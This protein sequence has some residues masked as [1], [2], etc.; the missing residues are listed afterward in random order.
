LEQFGKYQLIRQLGAGGMAEVFLARTTVAQ[1]LAKHLVIKKIHPAFA[2]SKH[3]VTM[4]VDEAKIALGL[5]HPNIVQ[6]FDF[7]HVGQTYYLAM[8]HVEGLD[9]LRL[10]QEGARQVKRVPY[11]LCAYIVQ[12]VAKGLDYAHRKP[13]EWGEPLG[14]VHRDVSP[15]NIIISW[16]GAVKIVDF[17][18]A[19]ARDVHEEEGV[20]KGKF[21]YMS[22]EQARGEPVDHRSDVFSA[23]IVLYELAC[24]RPLFYGKGKDVLEQVKSGKIP[25]PREHDPELPPLLEDIILKALAT[26]RDQRFTTARDLQNALGRFQQRHAAEHDE[27]YDSGQLAQFVATIVR[28]ERPARVPA[29]TLPPHQLGGG[30]RGTPAL[31]VPTFPPSVATPLG[32]APAPGPPAGA[33]A[34]GTE[35]P[36]RGAPPAPIASPPAVSGAKVSS[37][38]AAPP[39]PLRSPRTVSNATPLSTPALPEATGLA[40]PLAPGLVPAAAPPSPTGTPAPV[41]PADAV[42]PAGKR[43]AQPDHTGDTPPPVQHETR[44]RKHVL[45]IEGELSGLSS[46]RRHVG[47]ERAAQTV[48]DF[49]RIAEHIAFKHDA[50][51]HRA[52]DAQ[53]TGFTY[54][55]GLPVAGEDDPSRAIRLA[56]ALVDALDGIGRDVVPELRLSV[57]MQRGVAVVRRAGKAWEYELSLSTTA[58]ARRLAAEAQGG[59]VLV[60]G[61]VFQVARSEWNFEELGPIDLPDGQGNTSPGTHQELD[62]PAPK[63]SRVYR[64]RGPKERAERLRARDRG[65]V[66]LG[67][68]LELKALRDHYREALVR[69]EKRYVII[70]G[71]QGVGKRTLVSSFLKSI[72]AGEA[73][74]MR[75]QARAATSDTPYAIIADLGRDMLGL[76]EGAEPRE[77]QRRIQAAVSLFFPG[78]D[79]SREMRGL[80][81]TMG[82]LMGLKATGTG[83][84]DIDAD[85]RRHRMSQALRRIEERLSKDRPLIV[86]T[87]DVHFADSASWEVFAELLGQRTAAP[88][89]GIATARPDERILKAVEDNGATLLMVDELPPNERIELVLRRFAPGEDAT[90]LAREIVAKAGGNPFFLNEML[91][92]LVERGILAETPGT[93]AGSAASVGAGSE[94]P[95][96]EKLLRWLRQGQTVQVPASV[97]VLVATRL[98]RLPPRHKEALSRAA[99]IGRAFTV[100]G[101]ESLTGHPAAEELVQLARR[102]LLDADATGFV[103]RNEM[104]QQVAYELVPVDERPTLHRR[105]AE[106]LATAPGYRAGQDDAR[107]AHHLELAGDHALAAERWLRAARHAL[108]VRAGAEA[109]RHFSRALELLPRSAHAERFAAH[110]ERELLLRAQAM[111]PR[112]LREIHLMRREAETL[113]EPAKVSQALTRLAQL[114]LDVGRQPAARR[115]LVHALAAAQKAK[116]SLAE[117]AV[118]RTQ[119]ALARAI[120]QNGEALQLAD[121][122][123]ARCGDDKPGLL[124]RA[125]ALNIKG[126]ALWHMSRLREATMAYAEALVIYRKLKVPRQEARALN[127]MGIVFSALGEY[128]EALTHYKRALKIDTELGDRPGT[129]LKLGNIGQTYLDCG[130]LAQA[131]KY[132][133]KALALADQIKDPVSGTDS[134]IT[135]G[136]VVLRRGDVTRA[137][138]ILERGLELATKTRN[139]YQEIRALIYLPLAQLRA[140]DP[141]QGALELAQSATRLA[142]QAPMPIGE[143]YAMAI[144]ALALAALGRANEAADRSAAAVARMAGIENPEGAEEVWWTHARL[145]EAAGRG[146]DAKVA[147]ERA[148]AEVDSKTNRL[149]DPILR[150]AYTGAEPARDI[151][152][153][154]KKASLG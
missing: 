33:S 36:S 87:E 71:D 92:A 151:V 122:A 80:V 24:A 136:Q 125:Q 13:D 73:M 84:G 7:G 45:V 34:L 100:E 99:V 46:L 11:G 57:G 108:E 114:Y 133:L 126:S 135:L 41:A 149:R 118:L 25:R 52:P 153:A 154:A 17:G 124:E 29:A 129:A 81:Q 83:A 116:D 131:E 18:I 44:E 142:Q 26:D 78:E 85:E 76:A 59:E 140:G 95:R 93:D 77:V 112:Q 62:S 123:L 70:A 51:P 89:L 1:G 115:T 63:K 68:E 146:A 14:I 60:G 104:T 64:L 74:I 9:L 22:P 113:G 148:L 50:H 56:L 48:A 49:F 72:P 69:R 20:V 110:A 5:N 30:E 31:G 106:R 27:L 47:A 90:D 4:F 111:R 138:A 65:G 53:A 120:G 37:P 127:N 15:Q 103:F 121:A 12:Q 61:N 88:I 117:A 139:R 105:V 55:I 143:V 8:E 35:P 42:T 102:R 6:V 2:K 141:P 3:F 101:V 137:K 58:I 119:A 128:E 150:A 23:G 152:A 19:R 86:V 10:L 98:D 109:Y 79:D 130:A 39:A 144:E 94:G 96:P 38:R 132:L 134:S 28:P 67:R 32:G 43:S 107:L 40:P 145:A 21:A 82:M 54:V 91:D 75:A 16:D 66:V 147:L 97:E